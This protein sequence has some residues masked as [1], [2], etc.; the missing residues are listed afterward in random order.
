VSDVSK[1]GIKPK[2][3]VAIPRIKDG[4]L[5]PARLCSF[6][7]RGFAT[8]SVGNSLISFQFSW[9]LLKQIQSRQKNLGQKNGRQ[10]SAVE[11]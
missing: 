1:Y 4:N 8:P 10:P 2:D 3:G 11:R 5:K 6:F 9:G 7:I